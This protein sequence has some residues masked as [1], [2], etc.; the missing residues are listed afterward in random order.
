MWEDVETERREENRWSQ[1]D[2][3]RRS[4]STPSSLREEKLQNESACPGTENSSIRH[5]SILPTEP[6][7]S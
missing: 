2:G 1:T 6:A 4:S 3:E 7:P 5:P